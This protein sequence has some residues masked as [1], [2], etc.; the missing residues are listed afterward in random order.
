M[1]SRS[2]PLR[3]WIGF[4]LVAASCRRPPRASPARHA[5]AARS[6]SDA[7]RAAPVPPPAPVDLRFDT[8]AIDRRA[9]PCQD[10]YDYACGGWRSSHP[11]PPDRAS[12][13]RHSELGE[14]NLSRE[15]ELVEAAAHS[16]V[17]PAEQRVGAYYAACMD[18]ASVDALGA[19]PLRA[20]LT[21]IDAIQ[22]V[23]DATDVVAELHA[24][25]VPV[26]FELL[27][28]TDVRDSN[29]MIA[30]L[31][32][33]MLGLGDRDD[34][35]HETA[36]AVALRERYRQHIVRV[37]TLL[38]GAATAGADAERVIAF[39]T[40]LA[41]SALTAV[42]ERD[43]AARYHPMPLA[44]LSRR[45][46][47]FLWDRYA[48]ARG[49]A[50]SQ[51]VNDTV[52]GWMQAID[53]S[54]SNGDLAGLRVYLRL[55]LAKVMAPVLARPIELAFFDFYQRQMRGAREIAPR[56]KRCL[57]LVDRAL[58]DDVGQMF[59]ARY[60]TPESRQRAQRMTEALVDAFRSDLRTTTWLSPAAREA[61]LAKLASV[62]IVLGYPNHWRS[63]EGL[64]VDRGDVFGNAWRARALAAERDLA[65]LAR[66]ADRDGFN[67]LAQSIDGFGQKQLNNAG[68][69]AGLL[70]PPF[71]DPRMDDAVNFGA[72]GGIIGHE[73]THQ[74]DDEGRKYDEH[75]NLRDW[76]Q[77]ADV[78]SFRSRA[79][80]FVDEYSSFHAEDGTPINGALTLGENIADNGG[81]RLAWSA[82]RLPEDGAPIDG[83]TPAQ[84]FFLAWAQ[85]R[86]QNVT[87]EVAHRR[88]TSDEHAPGRWRV[89]G[90]VSNMSE[91]ARA[92]SC[93]AG[94]PMVRPQVC[95][96]W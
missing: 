75:G 34:Y 73:L 35:L 50:G 20:L 79:Q 13:D 31:D 32:Q 1:L 30:T 36:A 46:P 47:A 6:T 81:L 76:W 56:W 44:A 16:A 82:A 86:C 92:F 67:A 54:L 58:G 22:S 25:D 71:F 91:F 33:G 84:R 77:P 7:G 27:A 62:R 37:F 24:H 19:T 65:S 66:P 28:L 18:G 70:Q 39:E 87:P 59:V 64:R 63:Y 51:R 95:R 60:F 55:H 29:V 45:H 83:F 11:I 88:A 43:T 72:I 69:T 96:V 61:A 5:A 68:F 38:G 23:A 17:S 3:S 49:L 8:S 2:T 57:R 52:P 94:S 89:N 4:L 90:V 9:D 80:C 42:E 74:F 48:R 93:G 12:L 14:L 26:L 78:A 15:H 10:F 53:A 40:A 85:I 21:R 41:R